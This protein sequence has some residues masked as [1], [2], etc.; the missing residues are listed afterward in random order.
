MS[1]QISRTQDK[2]EFSITW[3]SHDG[4]RIKTYPYTSHIFEPTYVSLLELIFN[5]TGLGSSI[6]RTAP[7]SW[8]KRHYFEEIRNG[9]GSP[10]Q[11]FPKRGLILTMQYKGRR[12]CRQD[13]CFEQ[14]IYRSELGH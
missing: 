6:P 13:A 8:Q 14:F 10:L 3:N 2:G 7:R 9:R 5:N 11:A 4:T 1:C 12:S